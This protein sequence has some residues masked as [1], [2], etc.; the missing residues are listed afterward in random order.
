MRGGD[1]DK[2]SLLSP[3][4]ALWTPFIPPA[5]YWPSNGVFAPNPCLLFQRGGLVP[6]DASGLAAFVGAFV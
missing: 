1:S 3:P 4:D 6:C 5:P 2:L